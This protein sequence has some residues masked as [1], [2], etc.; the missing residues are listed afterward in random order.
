MTEKEVLLVASSETTLKSSPVR[1]LLERSLGKHLRIVLSRY[2]ETPSV[3]RR[4]GRIVVSGIRDISRSLLLVCQIFGVALAIRAVQVESELGKIVDRAV[5]LGLERIGPN[6][7]FAVKAR[8]VGTHPF[9]SKE[10]EN[11]I[12]SRIL[13]ASSD[14]GVTVNL[15]TPKT[16]IFVEVKDDCAYVYT[17]RVQGPGGLPYGCQG[18][19]VSLFSGSLSSRVSA[20]QMMKRGAR[21]IPL[22][23][24]EEN[25]EI[26]QF[27]EGF[28]KWLR[29]IY[30]RLPVRRPTAIVLPFGDVMKRMNN[31]GE[32]DLVS[33]LKMRAM[34]LGADRVAKE[35]K[36]LG[37]V[38]GETL[39]NSVHS[40]NGIIWASYGVNTPIYRPLIAFENEEISEL[41]K[42]ASLEDEDQVCSSRAPSTMKLSS[43]VMLQAESSLGIGVLLETAV[44]K[45][46]KIPI[47]PEWSK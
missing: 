44:A 42:K 46:R 7:T 4:H 10:L 27:N 26:D 36:A 1:N 25:S 33:I 34:L 5:A 29:Q 20:W 15:T 18:S 11:V 43:D 35:M 23:F 12:G 16:T 28:L 9:T 17:E 13:E 24:D 41:A 31:V 2:G 8:R 37:I 14:R 38:T 19:I 47:M 21:V 39:V 22:Y 45:R 32:R 40:M 3:E 30:S 6:S